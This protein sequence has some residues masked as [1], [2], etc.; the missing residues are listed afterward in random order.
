[1]RLVQLTEQQRRI[2]ELADGSHLVQAPPGTGKTE[3]LTQRALRLLSME[4]GS[5][6]RVL[7][8][9]FTVK[10]AETLRRRLKEEVG[11]QASRVNACTFHSFCMD[12]LQ[13]YGHFVGFPADTTIYES[14]DEKLAVLSQALEEEGFEAPDRK[15]LKTLL[16]RIAVAKRA[17]KLPEAMEDERLATA[18]AAYVRVLRRFHACDFDDLLWLTWRLMV[19]APKVAKH[20]RRMYRHIMFDEAQDTS[21][22]QYEILRAICGDEHRN[23]MMVADSDQFIYKF[24]GASDRWLEAFVVDFGAT[25]HELIEN[26]RCAKAIV[27]AANKLVE[28]QDGRLP[29]PAMAPAKAARGAVQAWSFATEKDEA[30]GIADWVE[31]LLAKGL[32]PRTLYA[33]ESPSVAL[34]DICVLCR[35]RYSLD[36]TLNEFGKRAIKCLFAT[37]RQLV[38]TREGQI[39]LQGL[40]VLQ[41]PADRVT[42]ES[43][44]AAWSHDLLDSGVAELEPTPFFSRLEKASPDIAPFARI[45]AGASFG[46]G[47]SN[48]ETVRDLID[49]V[50]AAADAERVAVNRALALSGDAKTLR[51]RWRQYCGHTMPEG[52]SIGAF[53]GEVALAGKS[54]LEGPGIRV[55]TVH[56]AKGLEF[57]ASALVGMNEGTLPDYRN[58]SRKSDLADERRI[59]YVAI[60]RASRLLLLTRPRQRVMP[61][62]D[63]RVQTESRFIR[64]M[65]LTMETR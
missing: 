44:L 10:A 35:T 9:T 21:R 42:R 5:T 4:A 62:G 18:Y 47:R 60:T 40:K 63:A 27:A 2:V 50:E 31:H 56:V 12:A 23:V 64:D 32:D 11:D 14:D 59:A 15:E 26:F 37:G 52:R 54:V 17:L 29:R 24:A 43:I 38:E 13:H 61:W 34:E 6:F 33:S 39:V 7:A 48:T 36:A 45:L 3:V 65:G 16:E 20:Y 41:N 19:E 28:R 22:A 53:L 46:G 58:M 1:M 51:E 55:L 25:R 57:K 8:L 49:A 30:I